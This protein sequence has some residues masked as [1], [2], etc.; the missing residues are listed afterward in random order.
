MSKVRRVCGALALLFAL[1][2]LAGVPHAA[3]QKK[4]GDGGPVPPGTIYF[5]MTDGTDWSMKAD[6]SGRA[7]SVDGDPSYQIHGGSRWFLQDRF[8]DFEIHGFDEWGNPYYWDLYDVVA[9]NE[10]GQSVVLGSSRGSFLGQPK[11][12]KDDSFVSFTTAV[13]TDGVITGGLVVVPVTWSAEGVPGAGVPEA[14]LEAPTLDWGEVNLYAHDW[15]PSGDAAVITAFNTDGE[16]QLY[17]ADFSGEGVEVRP[18]VVVRSPVWSHGVWSPDGNW[19]AFSR[20][21][22]RDGTVVQEIWTINPDGTGA[23]NLTLGSNRSNVVR[24]QMGPSW[25]PDGAHVAYTEHV[26]KGGKGTNNILRI[27]SAGGAPTALTS[28]G[29]SGGPRWRQ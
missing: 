21:L 7:A 16:V 10:A 5:S 20:R 22:G 6:G 19:I 13:D 27:P 23:V 3:A 25:S 11:W 1:A 15:S 26:I 2:G 24:E 8:V 4:G 17:V 18:L 29:K 14:A 12:G 9:V 28:D